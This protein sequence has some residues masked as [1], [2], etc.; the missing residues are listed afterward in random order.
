MSETTN[1]QW[2]LIFDG[3]LLKQNERAAVQARFANRFGASGSQL[4]QIFAGGSVVLRRNL[5]LTLAQRI[6]NDLDALGMR[7]RLIES[8]DADTETTPDVRRSQPGGSKVCSEQEIDEFFVADYERPRSSFFYRFSLCSVAVVM[9]LLPL[10]YVA[11]VGLSAY[12]TFWH[13][14]ANIGLIAES[15]SKYLGL[16]FYLSP[17]VGLAI[18]TLFLLKPLVARPLPRELPVVLDP[19]RQPAFFYLVEQIT[20]RIGAPMPAEIRVDANVN[21]SASLRHGVFSSD[22]ILTVGLPLILGMNVQALA[23][24]LAHEFGHFAQRSGMR[25]RYLIASINSWFD[26]RAHEPDV[27][28]QRI[29]GL[30]GN[31]WMVVML[32]GQV[33]RLGIWVSRKILA[34]LGRVAA[35]VS[36]IMARQME[37]DADRYEIEMTGSTQFRDTA[38][39]LRVLAAGQGVALEQVQQIWRD[40]KL[41]DDLADLTVRR[42]NDFDDA[43]VARIAAS[44][45]HKN[46]NVL[47]TH[48]PDVERIRCAE[49]MRRPGGLKS[50][51]PARRLLHNLDKLSKRATF[52]WYRDH[53]F[54]FKSGNLVPVD[55][56]AIRLARQNEQYE[57]LGRYLGKDFIPRRVLPLPGLDELVKE[58]PQALHDELRAWTEPFSQADAAAL[59]N[60]L[61]T[62][63]NR[64]VN[65]G[66]AK[67]LASLG[68]EFDHA[69]YGAS[70][71][72]VESITR[73]VRQNDLDCEQLLRTLDNHDQSL[74]RRFAV[75]LALGC[76]DGRLDREAIDESIGALSALARVCPDIQN[77][78]SLEYR[79]RTLGAYAETNPEHAGI[80]GALQDAMGEVQ[81]VFDTINN[82]LLRVENP[83]RQHT[84]L[85]E[86]VWQWAPERESAATQPDVAAEAMRG[87]VAALGF[88][89]TRITA[90]LAERAERVESTLAAV[91]S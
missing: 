46:T 75:S 76:S 62:L 48:P 15:S 8:G 45:D 34:C 10:V 9:L 66:L 2:Q 89:N 14:T 29:A 55:V 49:K 52:A 13:G 80:V 37:Y 87:V 86:A 1:G 27:W 20:E 81:V 22:L 60:R 78:V 18:L 28:D 19:L 43:A 40:E 50:D 85:A 3:H 30:V 24:I 41:P 42:A 21:A 35:I 36:M 77:M 16:I 65:L 23:G 84:T 67:L 26:R 32:V 90:R 73:E 4:D 79:L 12:G 71:A 31:E 39:G 17:L 69:S 72:D 64:H 74:A 44:I 51:C 83:L 61:D 7:C 59:S 57:A 88:L 56:M 58:S 68:A 25:L 82:A 54:A 63:L 91:S 5:D 53:G 6:K 47:D 33:A 70:A 38:I 11:M